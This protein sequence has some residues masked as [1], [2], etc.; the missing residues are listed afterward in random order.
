[1]TATGLIGQFF[2]TDGTKRGELAL[3]NESVLGQILECECY[4]C[5]D[6]GELLNLYS[7]DCMAASPVGI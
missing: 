5:K 6:S 1:M 2:F 7:L 3:I 4:R